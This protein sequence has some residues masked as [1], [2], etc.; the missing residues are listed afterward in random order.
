MSDMESINH[1]INDRIS[2]I[3]RVLDLSVTEVPQTKIKKLGQELFALESLLE[4]FEK[5]VGR[6]KD[7]LNSLKELE[8]LFEKDLEGL[9]HL[10]DNIPAHIAKN[11]CPE[12]EKEPSTNQ[13][14]AANL[15][16]IKHEV[17][18]NNTKC[19]V[20]EMDFITVDEFERIPQYMKGRVSYEQINA[21]VQNINTAVEAKYTIVHQPVKTL[22]NN[23]R[24]LRQRFKNQETKDTKGQY[25]VVEEDLR[26]FTQMKVDKRLQSIFNMLRHC[27]R[28][29]ELRGGGTTRYMLV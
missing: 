6:Q 19:Y 22:K 10:K 25:F 7:E 27:Q 1:H 9:Q 2:S 17:V 28:I 8:E 29:R 21:A 15:E 3:Q 23:A 14:Q 5:H 26:E 12:I 24:K 13:G 4:E 11:K 16:L 18:K 20:K